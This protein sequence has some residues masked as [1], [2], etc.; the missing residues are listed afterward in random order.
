MQRHARIVTIMTASM[1]IVLAAVSPA[2]AQLSHKDY[3]SDEEADKIR[4]A[5]TPS[6]RIKLYLTFAEDRLT[7][8]EYEIHRTIP[9][10]HRSDILNS[11]LN[12]YAGCMDDAA[13]Q[14]AVAREK[15]IG[16]LDALKLIPAKGTEFLALL[17]KKDK[18]GPDLASYRDTLEDASEGTKAAV[19]DASEA[20]KEMPPP[21]VRRKP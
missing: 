7:K 19:S 8:F 3:L 14:I 6:L 9:E 13:D 20:E 10:R 12:G 5:D 11:L 4:D 2:L 21:P 18:H 17:E 16:I 1:L 15:Q